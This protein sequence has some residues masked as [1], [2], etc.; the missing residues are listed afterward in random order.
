MKYTS[1]IIAAA[2]VAAAVLALLV[3][4]AGCA[5]RAQKSPESE[6]IFDASPGAQAGGEN[7]GQAV[8]GAE[9]AAAGGENPGMDDSDGG[10]L[11]EVVYMYPWYGTIPSG[12]S[13]VEDAINAI[14]EEKIKVHIT[15][16]PV[17]FATFSQQMSLALAGDEKIDLVT[18]PDDFLTMLSQDQLMDI[19]GLLE[20]SGKGILD[21][22]GIFISGTMRDGRIYGV[23]P[24]GG[25]A[26]SVHFLMRTDWLE[27]TGIDVEQ[28]I[29]VEDISDMEKNLEIIEAIF[30]QVKENHPEANILVASEGE[31]DLDRLICYDTMGDGLG[32]I[33]GGDNNEIVN[34]YSSE[35]YR[36]V[37][38]LAQRWQTDGYIA[39]DAS[40]TTASFGDILKAGNTFCDLA[41]TQQGVEAQYKQTTGYDFT[42]VQLCL[43]LLYTGYSLTHVNA[44]PKC[45]TEPEGAIDFLNLMY[46]DKDIVNL[47][48]YGVEGKH[49]HFMANG[50]VDY[51]E[52]VNAQNS[53]YPCSQ[54]WL[55]GNTFL[56]YVKVGNVPELYEIQARGN[57]TARR[58][59][60]F[61]FIYD[62]SAVL[63][64]VTAC[65]RLVEQYSYGLM[66]G[67]LSLDMLNEFNEKLED[68]GIN[69]IIQEKQRQFDEWRVLNE[70][71]PDTGTGE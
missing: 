47:L 59:T 65:T 57:E 55:F 43:P 24:M 69:K 64:E 37:V 68:A 4:P 41:I 40:F 9:D 35:A 23:T 56:D 49:Y 61:G 12:V 11:R 3:V 20:N 34:L 58:S 29:P 32:V 22:V 6:S 17:S 26:T 19:T 53:E 46:T 36:M 5:Q 14:T 13:D 7:T 39:K 48:A 25:K 28:I 62:N 16:K 71:N 52:G 63:S 18:I 54:T 2:L 31:M 38:L 27:E 8:S 60:A 66:T 70:N 21:A 15:L 10:A 30:A 50:T 33:L 42:A 67:E 44:V 1:R 51:P 45:T